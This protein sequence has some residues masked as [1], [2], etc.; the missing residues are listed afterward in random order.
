MK[1]K[2]TKGMTMSIFNIGDEVRLAPGIDNIRANKPGVVV[3]IVDENRLS[4]DFRMDGPCAIAV[5]GCDLVLAP[6]FYQSYYTTSTT[7]TDVVAAYE[8]RNAP[9]WTQLGVNTPLA[10]TEGILNAS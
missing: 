6:G 2:R 7:P 1:L 10:A 5:A 8:A 4:V 9:S 3:G